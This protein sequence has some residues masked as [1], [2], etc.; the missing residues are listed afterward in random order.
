MNQF[1]KRKITKKYFSFNNSKYHKKSPININ[2]TSKE[3]VYKLNLKNDDLEN[4]NNEFI[5]LKTSINKKDSNKEINPNE[6]YASMEKVKTFLP[7]IGNFLETAKN[8]KIEKIIYQ[9]LKNQEIENI[10]KK[11]IKEIVVEKGILNIKMNEYIVDLHK[12]ENEIAEKLVSINALEEKYLNLTFN[13]LN[14][15]L[16][17]SFELD[18][19]KPSHELEKNKNEENLNKIDIINLKSKGSIKFQDLKLKL[20][21]LKNEKK[22]ILKI[23]NDLECKKEILRIKKYNLTQELYV[24]YLELLE[25]GKD[26]RSEGLSWVIKEIFL[27]N[28]K[29]LL[30]YLPKFLDH[31][32][33]VFLFNQAKN[34]LELE[35]I[36]LKIKSIKQELL[37]KGFLN[38]SNNND[39]MRIEN[40]D[41]LN[42][43]ETEN[44]ITYNNN[45]SKDNSEY[46]NKKVKSFILMGNKN[47][48]DNNSNLRTMFNNNKKLDIKM[49]KSLQNK[50][51]YNIRN[52]STTNYHNFLEKYNTTNICLNDS[53][54]SNV[55]I[56]KEHNDFKNCGTAYSTAYSTKYNNLN[57]KSKEKE[58]LYSS[59]NNIPK[60]IK[61]NDLIKYINKK[62]SESTKRNNNIGDLIEQFQK[63]IKKQKE[64]KKKLEEMKKNEM[65]RI[66]NEYL[67]NNYYQ[68]YKVEKNVVLSALIG[69][70][71]I[72]GELNKQV[73]RAKKYFEDA[74]SYSLGHK[75]LNKKV[76][77]FDKD[78]QVRLKSIIGDTFIGG[79]Y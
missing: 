71:N 53:G 36:N 65:D 55:K 27:L 64:L 17:K 56:F 1:H 14:S 7:D 22:Q 40:I 63:L 54:N 3:T 45:I 59:Y 43:S 15:N 25:N 11:K 68:K 23:I 60:V 16:D 8:E 73:K 50:K 5:K 37:Y 62:K 39:F 75:R 35:E 34:K 69:E 38:D 48:F 13:K 44:S 57:S 33:K 31:F 29:V 70:D 47:N 52:I 20:K 46:E 51:K 74:K 28:K 66:F 10:L 4:I 32:G 72:N 9:R 12:K 77:R 78:N 21:D 6:L 18:N 19:K 41:N 24:H 2:N 42:K 58:D 61:L 49:N 67:R 79:L 30:S 26:T 76:Y